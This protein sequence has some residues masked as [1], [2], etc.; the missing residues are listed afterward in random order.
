MAIH[1][2][3]V[4]RTRHILL[5]RLRKMLLFAAFIALGTLLMG[6]LTLYLN[7]ILIEN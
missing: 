1:V 4:N 3:P 2:I 6:S 7:Y 5:R